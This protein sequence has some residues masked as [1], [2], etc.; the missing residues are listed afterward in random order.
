[1]P[2][3]HFFSAEPLRSCAPQSM[4]AAAPAAIIRFA[5]DLQRFDNVDLFQ[6]GQYQVRL[7]VRI[8]NAA[9]I[10]SHA[11]SAGSEQPSDGL[12]MAFKDHVAEMT[13]PTFPVK[14]KG[15]SFRIGASTEGLGPLL[16]CRS[17][18]LWSSYNMHSINT[19]SKPTLPLSEFFFKKNDGWVYKTDL[20]N[21]RSRVD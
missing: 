19:A 18:I 8:P 9:V 10:E 16:G 7:S 1:M 14:Y 12:V 3:W 15:Q 11:V 4:A 2:T 5:L 17:R 13:T 20:T 21:L 6:R